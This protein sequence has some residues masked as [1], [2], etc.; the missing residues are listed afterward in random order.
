[1]LFGIINK[2]RKIQRTEI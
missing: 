2:V 1:M